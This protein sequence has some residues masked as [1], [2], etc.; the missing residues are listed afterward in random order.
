MSTGQAGLFAKQCVPSGKWHKSCED[1]IHKTRSHNELRDTI[2]TVE[3]ILADTR[4][5]RFLH[6]L[7]KLWAA[8]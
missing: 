6:W 8:A 2:N 5:L 7:H 4:F 1:F 3:A